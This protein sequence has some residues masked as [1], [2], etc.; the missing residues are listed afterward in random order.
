MKI[1]KKTDIDLIVKDL[2]DDKIVAFPTET[3]F[4]LGVKASK[5]EN[6][7]KMVEVKHRPPEK[8]FT[9]MCSSIEMA[10]KYVEFNEKSAKIAKAL[11]PGKLTLILKKKEGLPS[12][13]DLDSGFVGI[14]IP[15]DNTV[16]SIIEKVINSFLFSISKLYLIPLSSI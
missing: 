3:V 2:N 14:R 15:D 10:S 4:G 5:N 11:M 8:P 1:Y 13:I 12:F 9:L 16:L 6:Y 7:L